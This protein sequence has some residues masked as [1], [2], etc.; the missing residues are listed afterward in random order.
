M[1]IMDNELVQTYF[2]TVHTGCPNGCSY[3]HFE[4]SAKRILEA[5]HQPINEGERYLFILP[6]GYVIEETSFGEHTHT[7]HPDT[8]RLPDRF[9][10][11]KDLVEEKI[12]EIFH[13]YRCLDGVSIFIVK[14]R[15]LVKLVR[16]EK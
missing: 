10:T 2:G 15:E 5:M 9:Q 6:N 13:H 1:S 11:K 8:L 14:V 3:D 4:A 16:E 12:Q 7:V